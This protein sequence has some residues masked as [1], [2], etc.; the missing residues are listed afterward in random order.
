M[1]VTELELAGKRVAP[2]ALQPN[3]RYACD[4]HD[5]AALDAFREFFD[6][7]ELIAAMRIYPRRHF[8]RVLRGLRGHPRVTFGKMKPVEISAQPLRPRLR[9]ERRPDESLKL[10]MIEK[11]QF[12][13]AESEAWIQRD[14]SFQR[15][16]DSLPNEL[17]DLATGAMTLRAERLVLLAPRLREWFVVEG[18]AL[19]E[20]RTAQPQFV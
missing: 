11:G 8:L 6:D 14:N 20:V 3:E 2:N 17:F 10:E 16:P 1:L 5:L 15:L 4:T 9:I 7:A 18:D 12:L 19:P 13:V